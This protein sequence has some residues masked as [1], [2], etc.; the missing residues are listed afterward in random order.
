MTAIARVAVVG[1]ATAGL[2]LGGVGAAPAFADGSGAQKAP[3][4]SGQNGGCG[5]TPS[6]TGL[7]GFVVI[8]E[9]PSQVSAE[10]SL[11]GAVPDAT[12]DFQLRQAG[13]LLDCLNSIGSLTIT[14]SARGNGNGHITAVPD[15]G[16]NGT[17]FVT[18][19]LLS[20][21]RGC[22][23]GGEIVESLAVTVS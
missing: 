12:Y 4:F 3:L 13:S 18:G 19:Q 16:S 2:V 22:N 14:T 21:E 5:A 17:F 6:S 8:G 7:E 15:A 10:V 23:A 20:C 1:S 11:K 9:Q